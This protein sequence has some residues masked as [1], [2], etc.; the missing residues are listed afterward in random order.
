[1]VKE[2]DDIEDL[3][4]L[5]IPKTFEEYLYLQQEAELNKNRPLKS[6]AILV[7]SKDHNGKKK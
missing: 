4:T 3:A 6:K 5:P 7:E 1:M 2:E